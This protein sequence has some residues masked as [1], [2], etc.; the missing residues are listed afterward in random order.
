LKGYRSN[1]RAAQ[2]IAFNANDLGADAEM[3]SQGR[4]HL[5]QEL[6]K[7]LGVENSTVRVMV[8]NGPIEIYSESMYDA[9]KRAAIEGSEDALTAL[10]TAGLL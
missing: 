6:R 5:S 9:W 7:E 10:A 3:D 1:P 8:N 4:V 2:I